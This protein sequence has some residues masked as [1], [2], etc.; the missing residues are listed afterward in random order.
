[1]TKNLLTAL[2]LTL[3][4]QTGFSQKTIVIDL[5]FG[6]QSG[7]TSTLFNESENI[8]VPIGA[9]VDFGKFGIEWSRVGNPDLDFHQ[10]EATAY[11]TRYEHRYVTDSYSRQ[12]GIYFNTKYDPNLNTNSFWGVGV[13]RIRFDKTE[14]SNRVRSIHRVDRYYPYLIWGVGYPLT[15]SL[16]GR[17]EINVGKTMALKLGIG[18]KNTGK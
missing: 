11:L 10:K 9:W 8:G 18:L 16:E 15:R 17:L 7:F 4:S 6:V 3:L 2:V 5:S 12:L 1:M 13:Q 14:E